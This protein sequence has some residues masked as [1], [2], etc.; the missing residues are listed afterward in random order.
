MI[1]LRPDLWRRSRLNPE[2][3]VAFARG[4]SRNTS[5][6]GPPVVQMLEEHIPLTEYY[7]LGITMNSTLGTEK[8]VKHRP[9][10]DY[11]AGAAR[12]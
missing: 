7:T 12:L 9:Q 1:Y 10:P 5:T 4:S 11:A 2:A 3:A 6:S 8:A